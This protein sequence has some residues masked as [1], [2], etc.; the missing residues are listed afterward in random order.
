MGSSWVPYHSYKS[1]CFC[2]C[3]GARTP[4]F[5]E[6]Y[7]KIINI[8]PYITEVWHTGMPSEWVEGIKPYIL[9]HS[10]DSLFPLVLYFQGVVDKGRNVVY[11]AKHDDMLVSNI[12]IVEKNKILRQNP[13]HSLSQK[14][15]FSAISIVLGTFCYM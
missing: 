15:S 9:W 10:E 5:I 11:I 12:M 8:I 1:S 6:F 4:Y 3:S 2:Y 7:S 14:S 13:Y